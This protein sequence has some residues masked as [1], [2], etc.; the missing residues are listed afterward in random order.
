MTRLSRKLVQNRLRQREARQQG[1]V[2]MFFFLMAVGGFL[3][4]GHSMLSTMN[5]LK[6]ASPKM[7]GMSA[8]TGEV[9]EEGA[10]LIKPDS[11]AKLGKMVA[12]DE[13]QQIAE[14]TLENKKNGRDDR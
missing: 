4:A 11:V 13:V 1:N 8:K 7:G 2:G 6:N 9:L 12:K 5:S 14:W 3:M 10:A